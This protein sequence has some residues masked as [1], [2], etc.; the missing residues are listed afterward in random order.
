MQLPKRLL[1]CVLGCAAAALAQEYRGTI[2]GRV[3]DPAGAAIVSAKVTVTN[4]ATNVSASTVSAADG[5]YL[6]PFLNPGRYRVEV[7]ATGFRK[8]VQSGITVSV[9]AQVTVGVRLEIG[10]V[11]E[12]ITVTAD[13]PMLESTTA[14]LGQVIN[15]AKLEAM[16]LNGR[17]IFMLNRL[18]QGV[19]WQTPTFGA[20][21]TSGLRPFDNL[22][23]SAWSMNGG[24][25]TSNEFLL[26]GAPNS[27]R[28]RY[29]FSPP[30]DAVEEFKLQTHS[31]DAQY[32][33]T[34]G[35][36]VNMTLKSGTNDVHG[37][38]W[39]FVKYG[40]WNASNSLNVARGQA[41]PPQQYNQ[42]GATGGGPVYIPKLYNGRDRT[43]WMFTW[44]GLRERV[45]FPQTTSVPTVAERAGD[46]SQTYRDSNA[47]D[48]Y[49]PLTTTPDQ[50]GRLIRQAFDNRRVPAIRMNGI[51]QNYLSA[52]Y[53]LPNVADQRQNNF[54]NTVNKGIYNYNAEVVRID[55]TISS[56]HKLFGSFY[57]NHRD[58]FRSN[59]GLQGT[60]A[61]QGQWPQTR[62]NHGFIVDWVWTLNPTALLNIRTGFTRF[63]ETNFQTDVQKFDAKTLG[64]TALPGIFMPRVDLEQYTGVGV[65][66]QGV[67]TSDNTGSLQANYTKTFSR[68]T[69]KYG[70][71]YRNIRSNPVTTGNESG[72][73]NFSRAFTRRDPNTAD[74]ASGNSV[75]SSLLG[76]PANAEIGAPQARAIQWHFL[77]F[78]VQDDLR[79]SRKLTL[80]LG[81]RW[82]YESPVTE[83]YN[84]E[85]RGFDVEAT[86][87]L[88]ARVRSAS[89]AATCPACANLKGGL[90]FAGVGGVPRGLF[91]PD[92]NNFQPRIG[93]A[94]QL[95]SKT[96]IRT[97]Y[98]LYF[99]PTGQFGPQ[100]GFFV[101]TTY[102][103]NDL[104]GRPGVPELGFNT[105]A[106]P[107]PRGRDVAPG[108][109]DGLLTRAGFG[110]S[111]DDPNRVVP[112]I[113]QFS[114]SVQHQIT[115]DLLVDAAFVGSRTRELPVSRS[116]NFVP[117]EELR[118]GV[119]Y[120]Q[121]VVTN[122][123]AGL[124]PGSG[125]NGPTVQRQQLLVPFPQ[126][127]I[128]RG[129]GSATGGITR[130]ANSLGQSSYHAFQLR[131][132][133]R[134]AKGLTFIS[135]YAL[136]KN[137]EKN[138][139][140]NAQDTELLR[141]LTDF[142]RTHVWGISGIWDLPFGRGQ[143]LGSGVPGWANHFIGGWQYVWN[144]SIGSNRPQ[145]APGG[146]EPL[147]D[148]VVKNQSLDLWF[149]NC[150]VNLNGTLGRQC[151][152]NNLQPAW[153]V[154]PAGELRTTPNRF[155]NIRRPIKPIFDMSLH[156]NI[157]FKER[158]YL[159][160]RFETFNTFNSVIFDGPNTDF[161]NP[162]FGRTA[163][164]RAPVYFP[165]NIQM[166]LKLYF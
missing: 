44:E 157:Y 70:G 144:G 97:G 5:A 122:P 48:I 165:R 3:T 2:L 67:N 145:D 83:R 27:T 79:V 141:Q 158:V 114:F 134:M 119:P 108:A 11:S 92:R 42:Y 15:R 34:G 31:F 95:T 107:F 88:A 71:E 69:L 121:T 89:G 143:K 55:H 153:R 85:V 19:I 39:E 127:G 159:E 137:I 156:K 50:Q 7:E 46:F 60:V 91:D 32:G 99:A 41:K 140:R 87:P 131:V 124:L 53:P 37:Q 52:V 59:N 40:M 74:A 125:F 54:T 98:G 63:L 129:D 126:F 23:G 136:S 28:G 78:F 86:S 112:Y 35:G 110:I 93:A 16:P 75:A 146:L 160:Y 77:A 139:F 64:F 150:Y 73:F 76:Y 90:L 101:P 104:T 118:K 133:Q 10:Q 106:N 20:T 113:Y 161:S 18:A 17:M 24:R 51:A 115:R 66:S 56:N 138:N 130:D 9:N 47:F 120:L 148:P 116:V 80:N 117:L 12:S 81:L 154:R 128:T 149:N 1:W 123:F 105:F 58:E 36:V 152:E 94:Y 162:N 132:E 14:S 96:V 142:D 25:V 45:P 29:N 166:G 68:H 109:A 33:R 61:N 30:V 164:P 21:G 72:F 43:F 135:S 6:V 57:R 22:G 103:A 65:G 151:A 13:A 8:Y 26:D 100:T 102:I 111:F 163:Q 4:E 147:G 82:D 49:D 155:T 62:N 38:V 84:R